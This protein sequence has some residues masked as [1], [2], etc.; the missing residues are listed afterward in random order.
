MKKKLVV[1]TTIILL[2][3]TCVIGMY[4]FVFSKPQIEIAKI[5]VENLSSVYSG[6]KYIEGYNPVDTIKSYLNMMQRML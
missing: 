6:D 5:K 3:L 2:I 4:I 1:I